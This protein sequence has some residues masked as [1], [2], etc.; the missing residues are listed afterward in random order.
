[1]EEIWKDIKEYEGIY[2]ISNLGRVKNKNDVILTNKT[3]GKYHHILLCKNGF[4]KN[5]TIH[6]LVAEAFIPN[7]NNYSCINHKNENA[8]DN[9]VENLEWCTYNYNNN[10]GTRIKKVI[11]KQSKKIL[12]YDLQDNFI[13][14]WNSVND[15][16][17]EYNNYH[18]S[19]VLNNKRKTASGYIW[20]WKENKI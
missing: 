10:Y 8:K 14:E 4:R 17:R 11:E 9:R 18:I 3:T 2:K 7:P 15:A 20:K 13:K 6:K 12:Q 16:I 19:S 1:M 5:F